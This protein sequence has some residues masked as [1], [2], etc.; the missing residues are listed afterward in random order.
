M[1]LRRQKCITAAA[2]ISFKGYKDGLQPES[3]ADGNWLVKSP[4]KHQNLLQDLQDYKQH[5]Q[6]LAEPTTPDS[7]DPK[8]SANLGVTSTSSRS[9][10]VRTPDL[11]TR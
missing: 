9:S 2:E 10:T 1:F 7:I 4:S 8:T 11:R 5:R 6:P 3:L